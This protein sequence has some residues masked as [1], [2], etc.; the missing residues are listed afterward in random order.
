MTSNYA[1]TSIEGLDWGTLL[2]MELLVPLVILVAGWLFFLLLSHI[3]PGY[4]SMG[5]V[6]M[7][8]QQ[9]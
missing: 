7:A 3:L 1:K 5:V 2:L 8:Y 9:Q 4:P 6:Y